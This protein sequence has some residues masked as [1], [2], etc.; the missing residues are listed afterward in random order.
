MS[1]VITMTLEDKDGKAIVADTK[2]TD[3][4]KKNLFIVKEL[5]DQLSAFHNRNSDGSYG[6]ANMLNYRG[7]IS[8]DYT[9]GINAIAAQMKHP[10]K[11]LVFTFI[12]ETDSVGSTVTLD[13]ALISAISNVVSPNG[14]SVKIVLTG[15][16]GLTKVGTVSSNFDSTPQSTAADAGVK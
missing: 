4:S 13:T 15:V 7:A 16:T 12:T 10:F 14:D 5:S 1:I 3:A 9:D 8:L 11:N 6:S 2:I